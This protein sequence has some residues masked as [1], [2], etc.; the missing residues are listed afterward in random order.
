MQTTT[1]VGLDIAKLVLQVHGVDADGNVVFCRRLKRRYVL[2]FFEKLTPCPVGIEACASS[3]YWS[4]ALQA[5]SHTVCL[6][7]PAMS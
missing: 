1:T 5:L 4:R 6:M 2:P 3:H 7:P